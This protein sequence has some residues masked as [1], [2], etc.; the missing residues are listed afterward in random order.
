MQTIS[1]HISE[2]VGKSIA[3]V[4]KEAATGVSTVSGS[5]YYKGSC[6]DCQSE[7]VPFPTKSVREIF[8]NGDLQLIAKYYGGTLEKVT[9]TI[10]DFFNT[11]M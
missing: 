7:L 6:D 8:L 4:V 1:E 2:P 10:E 9:G 11:L 5:R 3:V